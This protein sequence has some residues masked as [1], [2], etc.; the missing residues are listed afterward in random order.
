MLAAGYGRM[1]AKPETVEHDAR[2]SRPVGFVDIE[3]MH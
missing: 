1:T 2:S 3:R